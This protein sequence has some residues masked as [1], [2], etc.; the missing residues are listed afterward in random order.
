MGPRAA[1]SIL[2][3]WEEKKF[4]ASKLSLEYFF[5]PAKDN[6]YEPD[7]TIE[8]PNGTETLIPGASDDDILTAECITD[9]DIEFLDQE[10]YVLLQI[11]SE[12]NIADMIFGILSH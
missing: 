8:W 7:Y 1:T 4:F 5:K 2:R 6:D 12:N 9:C 11:Y 3:R 10:S